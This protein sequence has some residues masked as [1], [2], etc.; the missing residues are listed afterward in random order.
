MTLL[1][2]CDGPRSVCGV[3]F[4]LNLRKSISYLSL[5]L[6]L[7][8]FCDETSRTWALLCPKTRYHGFWLFQVPN[9]VL[10]GSE[11]QPCGF[12]SQSEVNG[13]SWMVSPTRWTWV[14]AS[15]G[16]WWWTGKPDVLQSMGLQRVG[17]NWVTELNYYAC[18]EPVYP[19]A[20][21]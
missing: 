20:G 8:S 14:W 12:E 13:F 2:L 10:A 3:Y 18:W 9:W 17:H 19:C 5:C 15:S 4:S 1:T 16:S 7:N 21:G 6:S 11:S